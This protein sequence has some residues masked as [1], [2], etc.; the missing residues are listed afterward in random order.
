MLFAALSRLFPSRSK[1]RNQ[2]PKAKKPRRLMLE[3]LESRLAPAVSV[4]NHFNGLLQSDA[5]GVPPDT[6]GAAG[7]DS[8]V[9]SVNAEVAIFNKAT[10]AII[11][12]D[13]LH[14][15]LW[16]VGG[17]PPGDANARLPDATMCY[18]EIIGRFSVGDLDT[19][20]HR[21][22]APR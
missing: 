15:F 22:R 8:Y 10:G 11:A 13:D 3:E 16:T 18:D 4:L 9:E 7:P 6:C 19:A 21:D 12:A 5:G 17:I 2:R 1:R 20:G 14:H